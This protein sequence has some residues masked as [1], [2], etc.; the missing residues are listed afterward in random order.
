[1]RSVPD[2]SLIARRVRQSLQG[3]QDARCGVAL[4]SF[5]LRAGREQLRLIQES[6]IAGLTCQNIGDGGDSEKNHRSDQSQCRTVSQPP[7][8]IGSLLCRQLTCLRGRQ[9]SRV[10]SLFTLLFLGALPSI[11]CGALL[12]ER[13]VPSRSFAFRAPLT[14][15]PRDLQ[16]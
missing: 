9:F 1:V 4:F 6:F 13:L 16:L 7:R 8:G 14:P 3:E 5:L 15:V 12:D 2:P 10:S 11:L